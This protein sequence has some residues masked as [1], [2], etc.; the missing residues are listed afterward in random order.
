MPYCVIQYAPPGNTIILRGVHIANIRIVALS[1]S[2]GI[3]IS[4]AATLTSARVS[5]GLKFNRD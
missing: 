2:K 5:S 4:L 1:G 3:C